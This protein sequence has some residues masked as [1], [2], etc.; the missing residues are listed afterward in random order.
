MIQVNDF[1][2][3]I[4]LA[5]AQ[6]ASFIRNDV[7]CVIEKVLYR[8]ASV[9][10]VGRSFYSIGGFM[11]NVQTETSIREKIWGK[12]TYESKYLLLDKMIAIYVGISII[13]I[14]LFLI[15]PFVSFVSGTPFS[16]IQSYL[17]IIGAI[18]LLIDFFTNRGLWYGPKVLA[19]FC[20]VLFALISSVKT[21][22][23]GINNNLFY[24]CWSSIQFALFYSLAFRLKDSDFK[25]YF[26]IFSLILVA[27]W[28][29]AVIYSQKQFFLA[30]GYKYVIDPSATDVAFSYQGLM[31][32]RLYGIFTT[33]N[34][35]VYISL[36][37]FLISIYFFKKIEK[38][39]YKT[40]FMLAIIVFAN[41]VILT[42]SR[43]A[44]VSMMVV[45]AWW[46]A[47]AFI[48][49]NKSRK[50]EVLKVI[51]STL[52]SCVLVFIL[53]GLVRSIDFMIQEMVV[54]KENIQNIPD[55]LDDDD[56][57]IVFLREGKE[58]LFGNERLLIYGNYLQIHKDY[59]LSGI[60]P[61]NY[62]AYIKEKYKDIYIT[63]HMQEKW[64]DKYRNGIIYHVHNGYLMTLV[65]SGYLGVC[66]M[67][68]FIV[69]SVYVNLKY[70]AKANTILFKY[71]LAI[72]F[73]IAGAISALFD[74]GIFFSTN[75]HTFI[76][77]V[78]LGFCLKTATKYS[79][80][81]KTI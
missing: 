62:M 13:F 75:P 80:E 20:L 41:H 14:A 78:A 32:N 63:H 48:K 65:S 5:N 61:G 4:I 53:F 10:S 49:T 18:L 19:L 46:A 35:S 16:A 6:I 72:S 70:I 37:S 56:D 68:F 24:I 23:Y 22:S 79:N 81:E 64:P 42:G 50:I 17:G 31:K 1:V 2:M 77:W 51:I 27:I 28:F 74:K 29:V 66:C 26:R 40:I 54:R 25:K 9:L 44:E 45:T 57:E 39:L 47:C 60:S 69:Y 58:G 15:S 21:I 12:G 8:N 7:V 59:G 33:I 71:K 67:V 52:L 76:F 73:V 11:Q 38:K 55:N 34:H 3:G 30:E 36:Y 43:S